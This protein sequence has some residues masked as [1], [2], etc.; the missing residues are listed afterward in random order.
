MSD[1]WA[2]HFARPEGRRYWPNEE[3]VRATARWGGSLGRVLEVGCGDGANLWFLAEHSKKLVGLDASPKALG[4]AGGYLAD[5]GLFVDDFRL[6][7]VEADLCVQPLPFGDESFDT[8]VD[9]MASQ[10]VPWFRHVGIFDEYRRLLSPSG[11]LFLYHLTSSTV[12]ARTQYPGQSPADWTSVALFPSVDLIA[13]PPQSS[14]RSS[15]SRGFTTIELSSLARTY[16]SG[17]VA[18]YAVI[19]AE[20]K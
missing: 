18:H 19:T 6:A 11:R 9:C 8:I 16:P 14:L 13:L 2:D 7:L 20:R 1:A 3:L 17:L 15:L 4:L 12:S 10:H 5:R